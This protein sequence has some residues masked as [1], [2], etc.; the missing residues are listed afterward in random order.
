MTSKVE[1]R[2]STATFLIQ[3]ILMASFRPS[4]FGVGCART[5][6]ARLAGILG[7]GARKRQEPNRDSAVPAGRRPGPPRVGPPARSF[8]G[9]N[10]PTHQ[11]LRNPKQFSANAGPT[12]IAPGDG[13]AKRP[14][15]GAGKR[16]AANP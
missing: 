8:G 1:G 15:R 7:A 14:E 9:P 11:G 5:P 16:G 3:R 10:P 12:P 4:S 13:G 2:P 6:P